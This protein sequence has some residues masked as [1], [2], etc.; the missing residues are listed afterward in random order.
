[1]GGQLSAIPTNLNRYYT[2]IFIFFEIFDIITIKR[3]NTMDKMILGVNNEIKN[4]SYI[5]CGCI[6]I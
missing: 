5:N 4:Y 1:M 3:I 2:I 6:D